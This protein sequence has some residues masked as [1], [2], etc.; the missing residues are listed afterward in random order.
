MNEQ[1]DGCDICVH[2]FI[3][4]YHKKRASRVCTCMHAVGAVERREIAFDKLMLKLP[5]L[6]DM[7]IRYSLLGYYYAYC[8]VYCYGCYYGCYYGYC[9]TTRD[10]ANE[11]Y[12]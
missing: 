10:D 7:I 1:I 4:W 12:G 8:H 2:I 9:G 6:E 11:Y 5:D 3:I